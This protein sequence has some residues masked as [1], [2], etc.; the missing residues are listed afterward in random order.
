AS[1]WK[2][3]TCPRLKTPAAGVGV[4][5]YAVTDEELSWRAAASD[6]IENVVIP[7]PVSAQSFAF[8]ATVRI[9]EGTRAWLALV[10]RENNTLSGVLLSAS[11]AQ[12][13]TPDE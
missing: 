13:I 8:R 12:I 2:P 5:T 10:D 7:D 3:V 1:A 9:G 6:R 4:G 11:G